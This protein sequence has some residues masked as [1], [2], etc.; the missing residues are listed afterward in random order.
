MNNNTKISKSSG[1]QNIS[2][3]DART[4]LGYGKI[5]NVFH[6]PRSSNTDYP[7][8]EDDD[9]DEVQWEDEETSLAID[10]K[11]L[12]HVKGDFGAIKSTSPFYF[13]AGNTKLSDC[14]ERPDEV[15]NEIYTLSNSLSPVP[16]LYKNRVSSG[17]GSSTSSGAISQN[18]F[19]KTGSRKGFS[20]SPP[21]LKYNKNDNDDDED[22]FNL[23]DL[24]KKLEI[25]TGN[26]QLR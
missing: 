9:F 8:T 11:I 20:S 23:E 5:R 22:I 14:F 18:S 17:T 2:R 19:K 16:N 3:Y 21:E 12:R 7:Y 25:E 24:V 4:G 10:K 15:L 26:F 1:E 13:A 6:K